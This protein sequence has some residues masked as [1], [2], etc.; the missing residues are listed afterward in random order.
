M[1]RRP[2]T[3]RHGN[4]W[5]E[6]IKTA[7]WAKGKIIPGFNVSLYR[8]DCCGTLIYKP[9][10]GNR[11]KNDGWEIDHINPVANNG[12]DDINNLQPLNWKNNAKKGNRTD[13]NCD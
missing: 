8:K 5:N 9:H 13:W 4:P 10:Y 12:D 1:A 3:D 11:N 6:F 7:V 2:N